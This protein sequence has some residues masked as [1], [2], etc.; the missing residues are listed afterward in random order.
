MISNER[1]RIL[2]L[3]ASQFHGG[4]EK[5]I[6]EHAARVSC[7]GLDI[8]LGSFRDGHARP[9]FLE[10]AQRAGL[11]TIELSSG[12]FN[13]ATILELADVVRRNHIS[14]LCTHGYKANFLGWVASRLT[15]CP[16]IA[17]VRGWTGENW[18]IRTYEALERLILRWTDWTVCV[19]RPLAEELTNR[20]ASRTNPVLIPNCSLLSSEAPTSPI[21]RR[22]LRE[23]LGL[24]PDS[25]C[26]CAAGRLSPEKGHR[27][28][29]AAI[30][31]L[32]GR[33]PKL[34]L[35][36]LG[37]GTQRDQLEEQARRLGI[38]DRVTF[39]GFKKDIRPWIQGSDALVNPSLTEGTPN[40]VLEAMALGTPVVA[41]RVGGVPE[42]VEDRM[43]GLLVSPGSPAALAEA[44]LD[45]FSRP[46]ETLRFVDNARK[47]LLLYSPQRQDEQLIELYAKALRHSG[48]LVL[49]RNQAALSIES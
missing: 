42:V 39:V 25:F 41:T 17:F 12:R 32:V 1:I 8:W 44:I 10:Q 27:H 36:L 23:A 26:V 43:S 20:R 19:S 2:H 40:V 35:L 18:R 24:A 31:M 46:S 13:P 16:Q 5:Q 47:R 14:L 22:S 11:P 3:R 7:S 34:H 29:I 33:I 4:P 28:L 21:D 48:K 49:A 38:A 30:P 6:L 15:V 9:E 45:I 37:S